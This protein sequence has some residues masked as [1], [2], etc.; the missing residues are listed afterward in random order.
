M[1]VRIS[2]E[3]RWITESTLFAIHA[4]QIE[5]YGG[6]HGV[7][8]EN[9]VLSALARPLHRWAYESSVDLADLAAAYLVGF[10]RSQGFVDGNKR[11]GLACALV[12]LMLNG[13][14][15]HIESRELLALTMSAAT[16]KADDT[17]VAASIRERLAR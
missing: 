4:Q 17:V 12:F 6:A 1:T 10:A 9:I 13:A 8:D 5:R 16:G 14:P 2:E 15:L 11:T 7:R 3:P